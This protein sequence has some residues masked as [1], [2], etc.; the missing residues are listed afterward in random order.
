MNYEIVLTHI[1]MGWIKGL[2]FAGLFLNVQALNLKY[3]YTNRELN[4][5]IADTVG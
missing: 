2:L 4:A 1:A 3:G 5:F